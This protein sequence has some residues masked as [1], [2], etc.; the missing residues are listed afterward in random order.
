MY[1]TLSFPFRCGLL[2]CIL[3]ISFHTHEGIA[4]VDAPL[5]PARV[6]GTGMVLQ[7]NKPIRIW[8]TAAP[9]EEISV[10][11]GNANSRVKTAKDG[12][13]SVTLPAQ[14][15]SFKPL[16]LTINDIEFDDILIGEVWIC[17]GQSNM[18]FPLKQ[19]DNGNKLLRQ[20]D[21]PN[22]RIMRHQGLRLVAK[23]GF[24]ERELKR[25]NTREFFQTE[26]LKSDIKSAATASAVG[27][28][29]AEQLQ[30]KLNVPVGIIQ[31]SVGGSAMNN[32]IPPRVARKSSIT[33]KLY[34]GDWLNNEAVF[35]AHRRR[36]K[37]AMKPVI[38]PD[39]DYIIG[40]TPY[41][42]LCEPGF[43]F[44]AGIAPL[45]FLSFQGVVWYQGESDAYSNVAASD[46]AQLFPLLI[47][48]WRSHFNQCELPFLFVQLPSFRHADWSTF[49]ESQRQTEL[50]IPNTMMAVTIDLGDETNIH[51][52]DKKPIGD[53]LL[54]L[55]IKDVYKT[56]PEVERLGFPAVRKIEHLENKLVINF[57]NCGSGFLPIEGQLSGFEIGDTEG[58]F[59][60]VIAKQ[61]GQDNITLHCKTS[62]PSTVRYLW[63]DYPKNKVKLFNEDGLPV[64]PFCI[65]VTKPPLDSPSSARRSKTPPIVAHRGASAAA[66]ENTI[67]AFELAWERG[68][69]A[70]ELDCHLTADGHI[71]CIHDK[72]TKKVADKKL[73]IKNSNLDEL[74]DLDVGSWLDKKFSG[75]AIPT[76]TEA[77]AT[78]PPD[79]KIY[80]E[81][82]CDASIV[83]RLFQDIDQAN[84]SRDQIVIISFNAE[85]I[86]QVELK[87]P[88]LKTFWLT[89]IKKDKFGDASPALDKILETLSQTGTDGVSTNHAQLCPNLIRA[90]QQAGYQHHVWTVDQPQTA[91]KLWQWGTESITTN[92]PEKIRMHFQKEISAAN[93]Q[94]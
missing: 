81:V 26:W 87:D 60:T 73:V 31:V 79:K 24:T 84:L 29:F 39:K 21:N 92:Y 16:S 8:G 86:R 49:R 40:E 63:G 70:I 75:T 66:P 62:N 5:Q 51:P 83:P 23:D 80:I 53:R 61:T 35:A 69:D 37:E 3:L 13:W 6:F 30:K 57:D 25:C 1:R 59:E 38:E 41:R 47:E 2:T 82:K 58:N 14:K 17:A 15:A 71:V 54:R 78:V 12:T 94:Q 56:E 11:L 67:P 48:S 33:S 34:Q 4:A 64:G 90:I 88:L 28:I 91:E 45:R 20:A 93:A 44:E 43:L 72:D 19:C 10:T 76:L 52:T 68:A 85:V 65:S 27:W 36:A 7:Q 22:L 55:A 32:W 46:A 42:W 50:T 9:D 18:Q 74:L 77:M 89:S